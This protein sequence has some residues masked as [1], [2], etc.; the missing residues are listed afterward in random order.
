MKAVLLLLLIWIA[1]Q[2]SGQGSSLEVVV[3][4]IKS[5][6]GVV[7]VGIFNSDKEFLEKAWRGEKPKAQPGTMKVTFKDV[8]AGSYA[9]SVYHDVNENGKLD[10]NLIG[11]PTEGFGFSN[12]AMGTFGPPSF[13][14]AMFKSPADQPVTLTMRYY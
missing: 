8:P 7:M 13:E 10:K 4:N 11:I 12:D 6:K 5:D 1:N 2:A 9:I 14:K 3:N